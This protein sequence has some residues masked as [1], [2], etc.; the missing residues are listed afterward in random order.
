LRNEAQIHEFVNFVADDRHSSG[1]DIR[2]NTTRPAQRDQMPYQPVASDISGGPHEPQ[3]CQIGADRVDLRHK[4]DHIF[5]QRAR[6][7]S[8]FNRGRG[9]TGAE[10]LRQN[11]CIAGTRICVCGDASDVY[12]P[13]DRKSVDRFWI[14]NGMTPDDHAPDFGC[15]GKTT[16]QN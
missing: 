5:L 4:G 13:C 10:R 2:G 12:E 16:A 14:A 3:F 6:S 9:D 8:A 1:I 11:E 15:L 7:H